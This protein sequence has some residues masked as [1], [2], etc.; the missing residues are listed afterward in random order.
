MHEY[1]AKLLGFIAKSS[2]ASMDDIEK[3]TGLGRD[4]VL[5]TLESLSKKGAVSIKKRI[6][7]E[8]RIS[9]EGKRYA[10]GFPEEALVRALL[11]KK[12]E[13][14]SSIKDQIGLSWAKRNGW[15]T[16]S[17]NIISLTQDGAKAAKGEKE[18]AAR[19]TMVKLAS[20]S[21]REAAEALDRSGDIMKTLSKRGLIEIRDRSVIDGVSITKVGEGLLAKEPAEPGIGILTKE[22]IKGEEWKRRRFKPYDVNAPS[23]T[24]Y[25]ARIHPVRE[26]MNR[27]RSA[28]FEMGFI[29]VSG[30]I[31][32]SAFWNFDVLFSPQDHPTR[33]MQDTFFLSNPKELSIEDIELM[34]RVKEMHLTGWKEDWRQELASKAVLRTHTTSVSGRQMKRLAKVMQASYP[35]KIFSIGPV[36]RN[37]SMDYKHLAEIRMYDGIM[38]GDNL[39]LAN[40]IYTLRS[41][42]ERLG[43][44]DIHIRPSYFPFTEPS[45]E[46]FYFDKERNDYVELCG[47][48]IIRKEITKAVGLN[49]TVLAW[50]GG[51]DRLLLNKSVFGVETLPQLYK[52]DMAWLRSRGNLKV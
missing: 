49:K 51:A 10:K 1:E 27:I 26:F 7:K 44:N 12:K 36:F 5:W 47:G 14:V 29:E 25:P 3:G 23:D 9:D 46:V 21:S 18:Y 39:T 19:T 8:I 45:L 32:E 20:P 11:P 40:L 13:K 15:I 48:G 35:T 6:A 37:E 24:S 34:R 31:I 42:Y 28:W 30:P 2:G 4:S 16:V 41:F 17:G 52:N 50:G 22:L 43:L 33:D 38:V